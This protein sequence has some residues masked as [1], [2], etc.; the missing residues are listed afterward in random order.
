MKFDK[1]VKREKRLIR[2]IR[3][4][5][6]DDF[7]SLLPLRSVSFRFV[8]FFSLCYF[9]VLFGFLI[10]PSVFDV[11][12]PLLGALA[13]TMQ[14]Q[15]SSDAFDVY[16]VYIIDTLERHRER[17]PMGL[18]VESWFHTLT[19]CCQLATL[20]YWLA[21]RPKSLFIKPI[22]LSLPIWACVLT[23]QLMRLLPVP[24]CI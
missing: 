4:V 20:I 18:G 15:F 14:N 8:L 12:M 21:K 23:A 2:V 10:G 22:F 9:L 16:R 6:S 17:E 19:C 1:N 13:N 11:S 3:F 5:R 7:F 24:D